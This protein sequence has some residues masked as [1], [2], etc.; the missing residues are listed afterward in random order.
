MKGTKP[1]I[2]NKEGTPPNADDY[3]GHPAPAGRALPNLINAVR[4]LKSNSKPIVILCRGDRP[5]ATVFDFD[6]KIL[7]A[8]IRLGRAGPVRGRVPS[9]LLFINF[10]KVKYY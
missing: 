8:F 9:I 2:I 3:G 5:R 4:M 10:D 6:F 7:T 1:K